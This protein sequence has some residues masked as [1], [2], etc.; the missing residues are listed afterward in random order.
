M[1]TATA[2]DVVSGDGAL[3]GV[4]VHRSASGIRRAGS[5]W[6]RLSQVR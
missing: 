3:L 5:I 2:F 1:G 6:P 4:A